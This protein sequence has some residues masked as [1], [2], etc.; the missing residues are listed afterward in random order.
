MQNDLL[1]ATG[2]L[3][4]TAVAAQQLGYDRFLV[5]DWNGER[6]PR[7]FLVHALRPPSRRP[8]RCI[9]L[10]SGFA[11]EA[12]AG[13]TKSRLFVAR[14]GIAKLQAAPVLARLF[15]TAIAALLPS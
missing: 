12:C 7:V 6:Y 5:T 15:F 3:S 11:A 10:T 2:G 4:R 9:A 13:N 8:T 1:W 14:M